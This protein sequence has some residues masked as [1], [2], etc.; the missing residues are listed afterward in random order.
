MDHLLVLRNPILLKTKINGIFK[1]SYF[2]FSTD[3]YDWFGLVQ[4]NILLKQA[5]LNNI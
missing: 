1:T 4:Y 5:I 3:C 2:V